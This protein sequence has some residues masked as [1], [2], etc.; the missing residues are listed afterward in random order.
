MPRLLSWFLPEH[1]ER[2]EPDERRRALVTV[3]A[4]LAAASVATLIGILQLGWGIWESALA[5]AIC[6]SSCAALP[7]WIR[8]SG[9]WRAAAAV[10]CATIWLCA[11]GVAVATGGVMISA[12]YYL[13]L[14]AA[15]AAALL[16]ARTGI[17]VACASVLSIGTLYVLHARGVAFPV[18]VD[19]EI[20]LRSAM[21]GAMVFHLALV[22]LVAAYEWMRIRN[23]RD[24]ERSERRYRALADHGPDLIA[25]VDA[26]GRIVHSSARN[27]AWIAALS[28]RYALDGIHP[29]DRPAVEAALARLSSPGS[30]RVGPL[31]WL[32]AR[33]HALWFEASLVRFQENQEPRLLVVA[34]DVSARL[35][36][37]SELRQSHKMQ[38]IGQLA[39]GAAHDFNNLLM[40][41]SG[42]AELLLA[43]GGDRSDVRHAV[44]E[45]LRATE[46]GADLTRR[47][48]ALARPSAMVRRPIEL[49]AVVGG[50]ERM[51]ARLI[52]EDVELALE[53]APGVDAV[54]ADPGEIE[55]IVLNLAL[56]ARDAMPNGG[57]LVIATHPHPSGV[58]LEVS[59]S[60]GGLDP[61]TRERIFEPFFS[62]KQVEQGAGLGLFVVYSIVTDLG[63]AIR[64]ESELGRGARFLLDLPRSSERPPE[65]PADSPRAQGGGDEHILVVEDRRELRD[66]MSAALE[67]AGYTV[68]TAADG[69]EAL[70][71]AEGRP[72]D[73]VVTDVVMPRLGGKALVRALREAHP[74]VRA[75]FVSGHLEH[76]SDRS[77][78]AQSERLLRK[79]FALADL[80]R[81]VR[82]LLDARAASAGE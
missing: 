12:H 60:G 26:N 74:G 10:L 52:G 27:P 37:E 8:W 49:N 41:I 40:A 80:R 22:P 29:D 55:Q 54:R 61:V 9:A 4:C 13:V 68:T 75:L 50:L 73:L 2:G 20:G 11:L 36:L 17:L 48:L 66:L 44:E 31:R 67:A 46:H 59:D 76:A 56:N 34:R 57:R 42:S 7:L 53:L 18:A 81:A 77:A 62:T 72:F 28:G 65:E 58:T 39:G 45:I 78:L 71:L 70:A 33:D 30:V 38:A 21:R 43:S 24:S 25:E 23:V 51:L 35:A 3:T 64:V 1:L 5:C 6:A 16:G 47:L 32:V 15:L 79:P 69:I 14:A 19:A 82:E 63:G